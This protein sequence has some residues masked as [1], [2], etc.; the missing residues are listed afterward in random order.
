MIDKTTK[1]IDFDKL[2]DSKISIDTNDD[3]SG[4][5][6]LKEVVL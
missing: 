5:I 1:L 6:H 3:L 2:E 4:E